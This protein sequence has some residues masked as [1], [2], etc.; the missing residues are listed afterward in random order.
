MNK[1]DAALEDIEFIKRLITRNQKKLDQSPP[2]LFI[3][4]TYMLVGFIGMQFDVTVWPNWY[5]SIASVIG[6]LLSAIVGSRQSRHMPKQSGGSTGW[7]FWLPFLIV[8]LS[9]FFM[10]I[11]GVVKQEYI[12]L[13]WLNLIGI[14]YVSMGP[15]IGK[16]P[17]ILGVWFVV[18]SVLIRLFFL[19]YQFLIL[20]LLGGG[21][22][23][24]TGLLLQRRR[25]IDG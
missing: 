21:S 16:G 9:G 5:W 24:A 3:W 22:M 7:M 18:M 6:G 13:F 11:T 19:D 15:L 23:L 17:V 25:S 12:S 10:M 8:F 14:A 4:G 2:F 1:N 20:G